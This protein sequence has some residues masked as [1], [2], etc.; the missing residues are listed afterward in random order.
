MSRQAPQSV[1]EN[2]LLQRVAFLNIG[3]G[4]RRAGSS[5]ELLRVEP[6]AGPESC[7]PLAL[8]PFALGRPGYSE[9]VERNRDPVRS[10]ETELG[11]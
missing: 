8:V 7:L 3:Q 2:P 11:L 9:S 1:D 6:N 4:V 10:P 5:Q